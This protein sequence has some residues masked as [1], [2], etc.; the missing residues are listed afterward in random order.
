MKEDDG[1][2]SLSLFSL[3]SSKGMRTWCN[4]T[5]SFFSFSEDL[6][7]G[8]HAPRLRSGSS[9][10]CGSVLGVGR[11]GR[12]GAASRCVVSKDAAVAY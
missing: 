6:I 9:N 11:R 12:T 5:S 4:S 2:P 3:K 10:F 8:P 1:I 7:G